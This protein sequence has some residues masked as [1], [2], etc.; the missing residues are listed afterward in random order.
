MST[1]T[2]HCLSLRVGQQWYGIAVDSVI[3]VLH[4]VALTELPAATPDVLGLMTVRNVVMPVIDLRLRF[5]LDDAP[6][7]LDTPV[8]AIRTE[9][10]PIG[11]V[12]DEADDVEQISETQM[13]AYDSADSPYVASVA[14]L[15]ERLL[16][17]LD[18]ALL[19]TEIQGSPDL[20][21]AEAL[22]EASTA[23]ENGAASGAD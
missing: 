23:A 12:V 22:E 11:L 6:L 18:T 16:L 1:T 15:P 17:L 3:E 7:R 13:S 4:L 10:G 21:E 5:G 19:R 9:N 14:R 8:I 20:P 2:Q